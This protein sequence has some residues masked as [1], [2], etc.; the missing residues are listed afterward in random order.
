MNISKEGILKY[1]KISMKFFKYFKVKFHRSP[2]VT[3]TA[4]ETGIQ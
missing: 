1:F 4:A 2:Q 3:A